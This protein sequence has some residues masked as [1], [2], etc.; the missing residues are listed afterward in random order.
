M[1]TPGLGQLYAGAPRAAAICFL[2]FVAAGY[3]FVYA[4]TASP[5]VWLLFL[6]LTVALGLQLGIIGHAVFIARKRRTSFVPKAYNRWYVYVGVALLYLVVASPLQIDLIRASTA[7]AFVVPTAWMSPSILPGD[8]LLVDKRGFRSGERAIEVGE[9]VVVRV[10]G[11]GDAPYVMRIIAASD[12][13]QGGAGDKY[14][15]ARFDNYAGLPDG[16]THAEFPPSAVLGKPRLIYWSWDSDRNAI[17]WDRIG[18]RIEEVDSRL[19]KQS[20]ASNDS[21]E[22]VVDTQPNKR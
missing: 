20:L 11:L 16:R 10:P 2:L 8:Y 3:L 13:V 1:L 14:F 18:L 22:G 12:T 15:L 21:H 5:S 7:E 6:V 19:R 9:I 17:R 4:L